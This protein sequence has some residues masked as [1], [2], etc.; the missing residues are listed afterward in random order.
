[1]S[2]RRRI[3]LAGQCYHVYSRGNDK[4]KIYKDDTDRQKFMKILSSAKKQFDLRIFA[5]CLM[6]NH[7]HLLIEINEPNLSNAMK[8]I[9]GSYS[10]YF[11]WRHKRSGHLF[12]GR[13]GAQFV[14]QLRFLA[15]VTRY[16]HLNPYRSGLSDRF[17]D[18][19]WS[20]IH[21]YTGKDGFRIAETGWLEGKFGPGYDSAVKRY[22]E[23]LLE[24][25]DPGIVRDG[26]ADNL[27][28]GS[29]SFAQVIKD[30][31]K[32]AEYIITDTRARITCDPAE[33]IAAVARDAGVSINELKVKKGRHNH[34]KSMAIYLVSKN[35]NLTY[36]EIG[37]AFNNLEVS[38]VRKRVYKM[39]KDINSNRSLAGDVVRLESF[40]SRGL[41]HTL[42]SD[43][44]VCN[45]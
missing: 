30:R 13:Y 17:I 28:L 39:R 20:S 11:N 36:A 10:T 34:A 16:I 2:R 45:N 19:R 25:S 32:H 29:K 14:E 38:V 12:Q 27:V 42:G 44:K 6:P 5:Y 15:E 18:Y 33:I 31:A 9:N 21:E 1:M 41:L 37:K 7:Y 22:M 24:K 4:K 40:L 3:Q 23:Y 43:P 26:M 8:F 35:S